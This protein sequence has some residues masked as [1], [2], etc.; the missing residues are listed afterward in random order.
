VTGL[1]LDGATIRD[2]AG[3]DAI[4]TGANKNPPGTLKIDI[5]APTVTRVVSSPRTG[6]VTTGRIV[7]I[8]L[9]MSEPTSVSGSPTLL[10][11][12]GGAGL[13]DAARSSPRALVLDYTVQSN[14]ITSGLQVSGLRLSSGDSIQDLA[15]N[16]ASMA[17]AGVDL[18]LRVNTTVSAPS[19]PTGGSFTIADGSKLDLFGAS[20]AHVSFAGSQG[21]LTLFDSLDFNGNVSGMAGADTLDLADLPFQ[22]NTTPGY[23][24]N[25]SNTGGALSVAEGANTVNLALLGMYLASS[26][27]AS[28]DGPRWQAGHRSAAKLAIACAVAWVTGGACAQ[29]PLRSDRYVGMKP[30]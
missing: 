15:G 25:G 28:G 19:G 27:V 3:N 4:L 5:T 21:G 10:L 9:D 14:E 1:I 17:G 2:G 12:D 18:G 13:F 6:E 22:G 7:T 11:N 29:P 16:D 30:Q 24:Q 20:A 8:T 23:A 26:F